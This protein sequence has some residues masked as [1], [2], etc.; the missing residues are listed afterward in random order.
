MRYN[1]RRWREGQEGDQDTVLKDCEGLEVVK[2]AI[3]AIDYAENFDAK[4]S[5]L[6]E[7]LD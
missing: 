2:Q 6:E 4:V 5:D 1:I 3:K 7:E